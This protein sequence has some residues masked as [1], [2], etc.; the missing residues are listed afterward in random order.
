M[1]HKKEESLGLLNTA[2]VPNAGKGRLLGLWVPSY[3]CKAQLV[4]HPHIL[5]KL[6]LWEPVWDPGKY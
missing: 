2:L 6:F 1:T 3:L 5:L 4:S